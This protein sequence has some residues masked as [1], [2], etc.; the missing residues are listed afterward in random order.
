VT[1]SKVNF[2][3]RLALLGP[4]LRVSRDT[5]IVTGDDSDAIA[6]APIGCTAEPIGDGVT[7]ICP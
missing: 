3:L 7:D 2:Q 1:S 4:I 5:A 6:T